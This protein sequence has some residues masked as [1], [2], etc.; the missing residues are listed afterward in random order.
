MGKNAGGF[1]P[2]MVGVT[3]TDRP[4][5]KQLIQLCIEVYEYGGPKSRWDF[6]VAVSDAISEQMNSEGGT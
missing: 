1:K 6:G 5:L 3:F 4:A 2:T